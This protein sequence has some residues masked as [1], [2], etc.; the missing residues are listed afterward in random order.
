M[1]YEHSIEEKE[2]TSDEL[3]Q[4]RIP[5]SLENKTACSEANSLVEMDNNCTN[6]DS[7]CKEDQQCSKPHKKAVM[8]CKNNLFLTLLN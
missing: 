6:L 7:N 2:I 1:Q 3:T 8:V 5:V 4:K